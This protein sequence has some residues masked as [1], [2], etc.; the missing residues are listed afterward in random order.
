MPVSQQVTT[1]FRQKPVRSKP[2]LHL[3]SYCG[4]VVSGCQWHR[5]PVT[6]ARL[7]QRLMVARARDVEP[8]PY[9]TWH[10][11][12]R[13]AHAGTAVKPGDQFAVGLCQDPHHL[14]LHQ[15]GEKTCAAE[16]GIDLM[17]E[18]ERLAAAGRMLGFLPP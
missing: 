14:D 1:N 11:V 3:V 12:R 10:H 15:R 8:N 5:P 13:A 18:A 4:C 2:H 9:V 6:L 7:I 16:W 17:Q